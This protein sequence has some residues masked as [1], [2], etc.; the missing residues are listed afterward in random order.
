VRGTA[1]GEVWDLDNIVK[2]TLEAMEGVF[3]ARAWERLAA[4][5]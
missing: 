1:P 5:E 2:L 3:G 4:T